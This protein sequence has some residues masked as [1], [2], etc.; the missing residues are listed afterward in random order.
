MGAHDIQA[1]DH[2]DSRVGEARIV[3]TCRQC[4]EGATIAWASYDPHVDLEQADRNPQ[5]YW[6]RKFMDGLL[7]FV[8]A[9]FI[10]H[11]TLWLIR[12]LRARR[13]G[14]ARHS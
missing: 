1:V 13:S 12:S 14:A 2:P 3:D 8:F 7:L 4:H 5:A 11:T 9:F 10:V 6:A